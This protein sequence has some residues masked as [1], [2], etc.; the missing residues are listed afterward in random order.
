MLNNQINHIK[1]IF[2]NTLKYM[3]LDIICLKK[4]REKRR[5]IAQNT[6]VNPLIIL[7]LTRLKLSK[8]KISM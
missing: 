7:W 8:H 3:E 2:L 6:L 4:G 1:I 5:K